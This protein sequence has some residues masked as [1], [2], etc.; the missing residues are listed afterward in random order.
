MRQSKSFMSQ[1][2]RRVQS[3]RDGFLNEDPSALAVKSDPF[4]VIPRIS[5]NQSV[6]SF[7]KSPLIHSKP[8]LEPAAPLAKLPLTRVLPAIA[9]GA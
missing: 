8:G 4:G 6:D 5:P 3:R 7:V 2:T 9:H 1:S